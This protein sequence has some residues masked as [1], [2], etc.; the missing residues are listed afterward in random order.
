MCIR[1]MLLMLNFAIY[2][3]AMEKVILINCG[4]NMLIKRINCQLGYNYIR[5]TNCI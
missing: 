4:G 3:E 2:L 1:Y 5:N